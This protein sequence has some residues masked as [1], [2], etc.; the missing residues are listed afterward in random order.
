MKLHYCFSENALQGTP[1]ANIWLG[2]IVHGLTWANIMI[3][4]STWAIMGLF[5]WN[6]QINQAES[7][8]NITNHLLFLFEIFMLIRKWTGY[9]DPRTF[10]A[11]DCKIAFPTSIIM[12]VDWMISGTPNPYLAIVLLEGLIV[13]HINFNVQVTLLVFQCIVSPRC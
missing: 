12:I 9:D 5:V 11:A 4:L 10:L 1:W 2:S 3:W 8:S 7:G 13:R 6:N